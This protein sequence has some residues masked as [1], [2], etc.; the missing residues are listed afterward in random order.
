M[1]AADGNIYEIECKDHDR[2]NY[3]KNKIQE[4][5]G[6]ITTGYKDIQALVDRETG[7]GLPVEVEEGTNRIL[8]KI[9]GQAEPV[10]LEDFLSDP[11]KYFELNREGMKAALNSNRELQFTEIYEKRDNTRVNSNIRIIEE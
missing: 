5:D 6:I 8:V 2:L 7:K 4:N 9:E 1:Q 3:N 10:Y 11:T